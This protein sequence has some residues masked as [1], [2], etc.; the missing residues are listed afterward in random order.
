MDERTQ[1][2]NDSHTSNL[3]TDDFRLETLDF[4]EPQEKLDPRKIAIPSELPPMA[5][6][7]QI[8][9]ELQRSAA[10]EALIA[11]NEDL[12]ARLK[13]NL[14]RLTQHENEIDELRRE[15]RKLSDINDAMKDQTAVFS[16]KEMA[17]S[18]KLKSFEK[19]IE[20]LQ[21]KAQSS[22]ALAEKV[23]RYKKYQERIKTQ[24]KPFVQQLK[25]YADNLNAEVQKLYAEV[26][27][28][29]H[30]IDQL[31]AQKARLDGQLQ[32]TLHRH[33]QHQTAIIDQFEKER[34]QLAAQLMDVR[35]KC[36]HLESEA[37]I[38]DQMRTREDELENLVVALKRDK[39]LQYKQHQDLEQ[40]LKAEVG[41][42]RSHTKFQEAK[43]EELVKKI[44]AHDQEKERL[45]HQ[46][47]Q[48]QEQIGSLRFM[49]SSQSQDLE[50]TKAALAALEK[51]NVE[52]SR[53]LNS[54]RTTSQASV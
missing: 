24:V 16:E 37:K 23:E 6:R 12:M 47:N 49:W 51:L 46:N 22:F 42:L 19:Q 1:H 2:V 52:L 44:Q 8:P 31:R 15:N 43:I 7:G 17:W 21:E 53:K 32:E 20:I 50:K 25:G 28:K 4:L 38:M 33:E 18:D 26:G 39:E 27:E 48:L 30:E 11:Q 54:S 10:I 36:N 35:A 5:G 9:P 40:N 29:D 45:A 3:A 41:Q 13:V 34:E 14:R